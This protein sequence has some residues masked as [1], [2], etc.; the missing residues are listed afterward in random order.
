MGQWHD[1]RQDILLAFM[2]A[3]HTRL[4]E[5]CAFQGLL[6]EIISIIMA[7]VC[8]PKTLGGFEDLLGRLPK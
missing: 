5:H 8:I 2:M 7:P 3:T 6:R 4:G 1:I